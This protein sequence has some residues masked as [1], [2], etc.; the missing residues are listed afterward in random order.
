MT[1]I[2]RAN[3][4]FIDKFLG[5]GIMFE[6]NAVRPNPRHA[7]DALN[8]VMQ[9]NR[10][11]GEVNE[12]LFLKKLPRL[13]MRVGINTGQ[14]IVG[15]AGGGG[16]SNFTVL[17]DNVNLAAR[18]E[19]ANKAF[20]SLVLMTQATLDECGG[21]FAVR[22]LAKLRVKGKDNAVMTYEPLCLVT[23]LDDHRLKLIALTTNVFDA[24]VAGEFEKC[25]QACDTMAKELGETKFLDLYRKES[26]HLL[27]EGAGPDFD[28]TISL[29]EK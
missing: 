17:G 29:C 1:P 13:K 2:I 22:P 14:M 16:A 15:D 23:D 3:R 26:T 12:A 19:S 8:A 7:T 18:L 10:E 21:R 24:F 11:M 9:M 25:L 6:F 27:A 5:D 20:G 4:G 28:G